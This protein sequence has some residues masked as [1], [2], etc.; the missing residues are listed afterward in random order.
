MLGGHHCL[1]VTY[2]P[3]VWTIPVLAQLPCGGE[4]LEIW[5][6]TPCPSLGQLGLFPAPFQ[7]KPHCTPGTP[8]LGEVPSSDAWAPRPKRQP[9]GLEAP[10]A[11]AVAKEPPAPLPPALGVGTPF[12][13][14]SSL[15]K[16]PACPPPHGSGLAQFFHLGIS[17][18]PAASV[19][20]QSGHRLGTRV[21]SAVPRRQRAW[22]VR[23]CISRLALPGLSSSR[24]RLPSRTLALAT[25]PLY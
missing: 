24:L 4:D 3:R 2:S 23:A 1:A 10:P 11:V 17:G 16:S 12:R 18:G 13:H 25:M 9:P 8:R 19:S 14:T 21:T 6:P 20:L 5:G 7:N 22:G 15:S